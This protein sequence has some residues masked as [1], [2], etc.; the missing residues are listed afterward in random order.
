MPKPSPLKSGEY[1][2]KRD[3]FFDSSKLLFAQVTDVFDFIWPTVSGMWNLRWQ[4]NGYLTA[5]PDASVDELKG[6]FTKGS[7]GEGANLKRA[8]QEFT[9]D[10]QKEQFATFLLVNSFA[11]Y[12]SWI[13]NILKSLGHSSK[14]LEK[15]LQYR[16]IG[17]TTAPTGGI[18][19]A[20]NNLTNPSSNELRDLFYASYL[21]ND[22]NGILILDNLMI[23]YR[24][25][26]ELRNCIMHNGSIADSKLMTTYN[27]YILLLPSDL[28]AIELPV[29]ET[30]SL[31]KPVKV[32]LRG[33][34]GFYD[35]ILKLVATIDAELSISEKAVQIVV[36]K[37]KK[38]NVRLSIKAET[39]RK[40]EQIKGLFGKIN[41]PKPLNYSK[42]EVF[43]KNNSLV[44]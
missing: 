6:K 29:V 34:V 15:A 19:L 2:K 12:E 14:Q 3:L 44:S 38:A 30:P 41:M 7:G 5:N 20:I 8:C 9:W 31:D 18:Q 1:L 25:F 43:L 39:R 23:C 33:V 26:K 37:S 42:A 17:T 13:T 32:N 27:D 22:K 40:N 10:N 21:E 36:S 35:I 24:C 11:F 28:N 16:T 4:V